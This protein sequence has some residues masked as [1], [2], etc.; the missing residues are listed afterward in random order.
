MDT[1]EIIER[2]RQGDQV[3]FG[4]LVDRHT[5][6]AFSVAFRILNDTMAA[7]DVVQESFVAIWERIK[8]FDPE[9]SFSAWLYR[10]VVNR[11]YD[12]LR[13]NKR[14]RETDL[15]SLRG[16]IDS[17]GDP[18]FILDNRETGQIIRTLTEELSPKQKLV[19]VLIELEEHSHDEVVKITGMNRNAVKSNLNH[20]RRNIAKRIESI[21]NEKGQRIV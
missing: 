16:L 17:A 15:E 14:H 9:K 3:A 20:A 2:C 5:E 1:L 8:G 6:K 7:E 18:G 12:V 19:F 10:I 13:R 11:A 21:Y 4:L